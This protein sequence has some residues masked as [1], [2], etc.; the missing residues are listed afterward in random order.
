ML[1]AERMSMALGKG[2]LMR[3]QVGKFQLFSFCN[4]LPK[5]LSLRNTLPQIA[6]FVLNKEK[7]NRYWQRVREC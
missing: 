5:P 4:L 7:E 6:T 2:N 1:I 3:M